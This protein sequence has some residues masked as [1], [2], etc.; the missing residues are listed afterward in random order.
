[1]TFFNFTNFGFSRLLLRISLFPRPPH[2]QFAEG[3]TSVL[4]DAAALFTCQ[5]TYSDSHGFNIHCDFSNQEPYCVHLFLSTH[6]GPPKA[7][8]SDWRDE[9]KSRPDRWEPVEKV[10]AERFPGVCVGEVSPSDN[11][12]VCR[13]GRHGLMKLAILLR[14]SYSALC[15]GRRVWDFSESKIRSLSIF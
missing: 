13:S 8:G 2:Q 12:G 7:G 11:Q 10:V 6:P 5:V 15:C 1:M 3:A 9:W 14:W 4:G